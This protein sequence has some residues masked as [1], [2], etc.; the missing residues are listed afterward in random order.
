MTKNRMKKTNTKKAPLYARTATI[1]RSGEQ[2]R[3]QLNRLL[4]YAATR[5]CHIHQV[6]TDFG[7]SG[8]TDKR[9]ALTRL[10]KDAKER[11]FAALLVENPNRIARNLTLLARVRDRLRRSA[12]QVEFLAAHAVAPRP[13]QKK[14]DGARR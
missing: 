14:A 11:K 5:G 10:L 6:Y 3:R 7:Y 2:A 13:R 9:P 4:A 1:E 12:V 8:V